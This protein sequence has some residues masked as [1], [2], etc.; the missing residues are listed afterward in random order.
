[1]SDWSNKS[2]FEINKAV[3][4]ANGYEISNYFGGDSCWIKSKTEGLEDCLTLLPDYCNSWADMGPII[5]RE[6]ISIIF[7]NLT[8]VEACTNFSVCRFSYGYQS[9]IWDDSPNPL[10]AAAI[11]YL[12]SKE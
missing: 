5:E 3:A 8:G 11:V 9:K 6:K 2:D 10:R 1:M 4:V 7:D 12:E